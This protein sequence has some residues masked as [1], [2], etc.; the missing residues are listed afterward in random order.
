MQRE[1]NRSKLFTRRAVLLAGGQLALLG[2]LAARLYYLQVMQAGKFAVLADENRINLSLLAPPRGRILDRFGV[3]LATNNQNYRVVLVAEQAGDIE[4]TLDA[5]HKL[6]NLSE[7]DRRRVLRDIRRKHS[8]VP[9]VARAN[10]TWDEVARIE[11]N[12]PELPGVTIEQGMTRHYPFGDTAAHVIGYVAPVAEKELTGDPLL[13]LPDFRI[14]KSGIEKSHDLD[15]R[16]TAGTSEV[17]VNAFGRVVRELSREEADSGK[18]IVLGLDMALQ[19]LAARRCAAEQSAACVLLDAVTGDVLALVSS[20]GFDPVA[21]GAGLT[22]V[23]WRDLVANPRN[24]LSNKAVAGTYAPGSTFKPMVALAGLESGVITPETLVSCPGHFA[25]GNTVWHCWKK[26]GHGTVN[27]RGAIKGSCDVFFYETARRLG[28]D[29]IAAMAKRFG[30]GG[31]LDFEIPGE[32]TGNIPT[33]QWNLGKFGIPWQLGE[34]I[35]AGIGQSKVAVTPLQL[36]T[37]VARLVT[38]RAVVPRMTRPSGIM[39]PPGIEPSP[40]PP[41]SFPALGIS[42]KDLRL[43]LEGMYAVVNEQGGTAYGA[44]IREAGLEM[45]GKSGTSQVRHISQAERDHG[46]RKIKDVPWKE[47]DHALFVAFAP[48]VAP[49]YVCAVVIEHGGESAGGGSAV[50]APICRDLLREA[51]LRDPGR[52]V[53]DVEFVAHRDDAPDTPSHHG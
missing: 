23:M 5:I 17:E 49:R 3:P 33:T 4:A 39:T 53:P 35:S 7:S 48:V 31:R 41:S 19:D 1:I 9:I 21:F 43:V 34:T 38:N 12:V 30:F 8:F 18:E 36:A 24:P 14:G 29:R 13:E 26:G 32:A 47:R 46:L 27:L 15:L 25:L 37:M 44:R 10:L 40:D 28:I 52:R 6:V 20:P 2:T 51:Q 45:G 42:P 50:A 11:V 16:G 22:P